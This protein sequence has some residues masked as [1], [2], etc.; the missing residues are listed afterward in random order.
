MGLSFANCI[1]SC[2]LSNVRQV[3]LLLGLQLLFF[4]GFSEEDFDDDDDDDDEVD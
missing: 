2:H 1:I 4:D 3:L